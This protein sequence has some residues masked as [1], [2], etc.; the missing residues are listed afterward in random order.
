MLLLLLADKG[1][2]WKIDA[3]KLYTSLHK[4][5]LVRWAVGHKHQRIYKYHMAIHPWL[6][7]TIVA[8]GMTDCLAWVLNIINIPVGTV[9]ISLFIILH[10]EVWQRLSKDDHYKFSL[11]GKL[12]RLGLSVQEE[13]ILTGFVTA[14][15]L[16]DR[17]SFSIHMPVSI[18]LDIMDVEKSGL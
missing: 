5:L 9:R 4:Q 12:R 2:S 17:L 7:S 16:T 8:N 3:V 18:C 14:G 10:K 1:L 13:F 11:M 15:V 6:I